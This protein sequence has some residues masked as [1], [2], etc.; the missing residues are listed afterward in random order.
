[1]AGIYIHRASN[2]YVVLALALV[3]YL[4]YFCFLS[5]F[6]GFPTQSDS[7][8]SYSYIVEIDKSW[9]ADE[10]PEFANLLA[11]QHFK[12]QKTSSEIRDRE[13]AWTDLNKNLGY[14][15]GEN[16][17]NHIAVIQTEQAIDETTKERIIKS[18][19]Y[20]RS[21]NHSNTHEARNGIA[22]NGTVERLLLPLLLLGIILYFSILH[23]ATHSNLGSNK[24]TIESL[25][26]AGAHHS[27]LSSVF[28]KNAVGNIVL[29]TLI[30]IILFIATLYLINSIF[31]LNIQDFSIAISLKSILIPT[32]IV[33]S[34][35]LTMVL[36]KVDK[37]LKSI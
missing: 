36:W 25:V 7:Q 5:L 11:V 22:I 19:P 12:G 9:N 30:A 8:S 18:A 24:K 29:S 35:H 16:P 4:G 15:A 2:K 33:F 21:I 17:L 26:V 20:V 13:Q 37:Y 14:E 34:I 27:K 6:E 1:M 3:L 28:R 31:H 10:F 32:I 23:G